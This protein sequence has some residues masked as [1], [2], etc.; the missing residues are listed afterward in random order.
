MDAAR[1]AL[2]PVVG[3]LLEPL[4]TSPA[5]LLGTGRVV[6]SDLAAAGPG[7]AGRAG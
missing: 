3:R 5:V 6:V 7:A 2:G 1:E 4:M